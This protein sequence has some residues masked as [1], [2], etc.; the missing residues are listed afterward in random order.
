MRVILVNPRYLGHQVAGR[1]CRHD[2]LLDARDAALGTVSRQ[3][4]QDREAWAW[5]EELSWPALVPQDLWE[6]VNKRIKNTYGSARRRPRAE[7][8]KYLL[9]GLLRC[10]HCGKAMFGNTAKGKA[11]Y[12]CAATRPDYATPSVPGHPPTYMVR[13]ER[14]SPSSTRGSANSRRQ[15]ASTPRSPQS[16]T[17]TSRRVPS[18]PQSLRPDSGSVASKRNWRGWSPPSEPAW[19]P[20][21]RPGRAARPKPRSV[22][23][24]WGRSR[25]RPG[26]LAEADVRAVLSEAG[27]LVNVLGEADRVERASLY[28][29]LGLSLRYEK[30]TPTGQ[31][32]VRA[33]LELS[34]GGGSV[35][36]QGARASAAMKL[37]AGGLCICSRLCAALLNVARPSL[38]SPETRPKG[39][40]S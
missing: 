19:T 34:R 1:Q 33:R 5:S 38:G 24:D 13:E 8:G 22:I 37:L 35:A 32:L 31:E 14:C 7:A 25:E 11:Y 40:R 9:A 21:S 20:C 36:N 17:R 18:R 28:Q 26:L 4:W 23:D 29:A 10:G 6:S 30:E 2:E 12:R 39:R 15:T 27:G 3:H 16:W